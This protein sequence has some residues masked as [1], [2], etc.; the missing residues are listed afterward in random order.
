MLNISPKSIRPYVD[1]SIYES[2]KKLEKRSVSKVLFKNI[3]RPGNS[4][5]SRS[6]PALDS[7][8]KVVGIVTTL[9]HMTDR[10][11]YNP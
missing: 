10:N 5:N 6:I 7:E 11:L 9:I 3:D 2:F 4:G 1:T 8:Y